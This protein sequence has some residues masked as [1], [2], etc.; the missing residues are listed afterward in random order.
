[1][2]VVRENRV[3]RQ[4]YARAVL[5]AVGMPWDLRRYVLTDG[6]YVEH[7]PDGVD[8]VLSV[9]KRLS[10]DEAELLMSRIYGT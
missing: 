3:A 5:D 6:S 9:R 10:A 8:V 1:M 7:G 4:A 2:A